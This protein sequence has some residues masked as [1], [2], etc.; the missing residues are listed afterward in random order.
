MIYLGADHAGYHLK[1]ELKPFLQKLGYEYQD[2]GAEEF[3]PTDDYPDFAKLVG[4]K[5]S[6]TENLGIL[7]CG[8]GLGMCLAVN[9]IVGARGAAAWD[10]ATAKQAKEHLDA[11]VLCLAGQILSLDQVKEIVKIWL[12]SKFSEEERHQRRLEK[13]SRI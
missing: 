13:I 9:K 5:V 7:I 6:N 11:N 10:K 3:D 2:L 4:E 12:D 1:E 8:T